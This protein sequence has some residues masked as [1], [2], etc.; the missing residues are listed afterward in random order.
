MT[1]P[2]TPLVDSTW[3]QTNLDNDRIVILDASTY[4]QTSD[5]TSIDCIPKAIHFDLKESFSD[6]TSNFPNTIPTPTQFEKQCRTLGISNAS[7]IIVY[8]NKGI[9][10]SPRVWW[11]FRTMGHNEVYV[12]NGGLP[13]WQRKKYP[14]G[15]LSLELP[16]TSQYTAHFKAG[17]VKYYADIIRLLNQNDACIIDARSEGRFTGI[18]PEPRPNLKSG[19]IPNSI[20]LPYTTVLEDGYFK[21]VS[22][23]KAI[24]KSLKLANKQLVFCC[25]SGITACIILMAAEM[26]LSNN[27]AVYDGSWTEW[28][29]LQKLFTT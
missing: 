2:N 18:L 1:R 5:L 28:A 6:Q 15:K 22:E 13:D 25:G 24:F 19:A 9:Y 10:T 11:L 17:S 26:T 29:T 12:L 20:N 16:N 27:K 3:L 21:S 4:D 8:D 7:I 14:I 23:L